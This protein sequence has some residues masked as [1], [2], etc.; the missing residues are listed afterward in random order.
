MTDDP[1]RTL[2]MIADDDL[3]IRRILMRSFGALD[4]DLLEARDGE[5][6]LEFIIQHQPELVVLDVMMPTLSGWELCKYI[7]NKPALKDTSVVMLTAIGRTVNEMTSPLYGADAYLDKPFDIQEVIDV[8][9]GL[10]TDRG[11]KVR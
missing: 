3:E 6:A 9:A 8:V 1:R 11:F 5:E 2:V 7:R 10:L 4:V